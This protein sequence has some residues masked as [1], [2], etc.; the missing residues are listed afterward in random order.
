[1]ILQKAMQHGISVLVLA[2]LLALALGSS[3]DNGSN[4]TSSSPQWFQGGN[5]HNATVAQWKSATYQNK[6]ATASDWLAVTKWKGY[7]NSPGDFNKVKAKA[8]MLV[9]AVDEVVAQKETNSM[10]VNEIA[11]AIITMSND[12]GP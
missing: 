11:A 4:T 9:K 3:D 5:L 7:L 8:Q 12:F 1:M 10:K 6:L 2:F